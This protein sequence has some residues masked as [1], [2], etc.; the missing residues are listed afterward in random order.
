[1][2]DKFPPL[3]N[4]SAI[5]AAKTLYGAINSAFEDW[6]QRE[7][8]PKGYEAIFGFDI[9][10]K[11]VHKVQTDSVLDLRH[12]GVDDLRSPARWNVGIKMRSSIGKLG[13]FGV[14]MPLANPGQR[15]VFR[16][17]DTADDYFSAYL[18]GS[19]ESYTLLHRSSTLDSGY[20]RDL[21][22]E[23]GVTVPEFDTSPNQRTLALS[24]IANKAAVFDIVQRQSLPVHPTQEITFEK[25]TS[26]TEPKETS[27]NFTVKKSCEASQGQKQPRR[28]SYETTLRALYMQRDTKGTPLYSQTVTF[29][30]DNAQV[31]MPSVQLTTY[32][33]NE[34]T[35][36]ISRRTSGTD[37]RISADILGYIEAGLF[38]ANY[39]GEDPRRN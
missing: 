16:H 25:I 13:I 31:K 34:L 36:N 37:E 27:R 38:D 6:D 12:L 19:D 32:E 35:G 29:E 15:L 20:L 17:E 10:A 26:L 1:M 4:E 3:G 33:V 2:T 11:L 30:G 39:G 8:P 9:P 5:E 21:L 24:Q 18:K 14:S 7:I 22:S 28:K 23:A